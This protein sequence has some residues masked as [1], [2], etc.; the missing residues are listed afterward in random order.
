MTKES[1]DNLKQLLQQF[2][3]HPK[4]REMAD[5][6]EHGDRLF[7]A[8]PAPSLQPE[9]L[10]AICTN[11]PKRLQHEKQMHARCRWAGVAAVAAILVLGLLVLNT[12]N[13]R[14][15]EATLLIV[16]GEWP[17]N[18]QSSLSDIERELSTLDETI[19]TMDNDTYEPV[20]QLR[21]DIVEIEEI[22]V[23]TSN[24]EFWKG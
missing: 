1:H 23:D 8:Y 3:D 14:P 4:N 17:L 9:T 15:Y 21:F 16:T 6:I 19:R 20:N 11:L 12:G 2:V 5:D 10:E 7:E 22:E 13:N 24:A 18:E